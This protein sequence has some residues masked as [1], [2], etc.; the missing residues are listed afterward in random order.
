[1]LKGQPIVFTDLSN[2][3]IIIN[4]IIIIFRTADPNQLM[5]DWYWLIRWMAAPLN[6][7]VLWTIGF[8]GDFNG[9][10]GKIVGLLTANFG[11]KF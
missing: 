10:I 8:H 4:P 5:I 11:P 6:E 7:I 2:S 9:N 1:M 3:T